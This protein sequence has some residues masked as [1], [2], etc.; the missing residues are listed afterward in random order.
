MGILK[1]KKGRDDIF[2]VLNEKNFQSNSL[3]VSS[4]RP[5]GGIRTFSDK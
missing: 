3:S 5:K 2:K 1:Y 4:F